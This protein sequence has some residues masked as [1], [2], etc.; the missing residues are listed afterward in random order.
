M[1]HSKWGT[2][3]YENKLTYTGAAQSIAYCG[4][5]LWV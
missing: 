1:G 3:V 4:M 5:I 2:T